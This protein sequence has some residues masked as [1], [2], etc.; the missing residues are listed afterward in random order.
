MLGEQLIAMKGQQAMDDFHDAALQEAVYPDFQ[1]LFDKSRQWQQ[2]DANKRAL[3][4]QL[5]WMKF[6]VT[7]I[8]V[9][10]ELSWNSDRE[11]NAALQ[12]MV[13]QQKEPR[14]I[15]PPRAS[16]PFQVTGCIA[17]MQS[18]FILELPCVGRYDHNTGCELAAF[19]RVPAQ[20]EPQTGLAI[21]PTHCELSIECKLESTTEGGKERTLTG[22]F[23]VRE[24]GLTATA[25]R[26]AL[27]VRHQFHIELTLTLAV[28]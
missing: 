14:V 8:L 23:H 25:Q 19:V 17:R 21:P 18:P 15:R 24:Y 6:D 7:N 10:H 28:S 1:L 3:P 22:D 9:K 12:L 16:F 5:L 27:T 13:Q 2:S 4:Q 20:T 26:G 11:Q